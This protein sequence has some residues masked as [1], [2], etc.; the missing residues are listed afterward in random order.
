MNTRKVWILEIYDNFGKGNAFGEIAPLKGLSIEL[1]DEENFHLKLQEVIEN[2]EYYIHHLDELRA[3]PS[4]LFGVEMAYLAYKRPS[5]ILFQTD[6]TLGKKSIP[7]NALVWMNDAET[8]KKDVDRLLKTKADCI[9]LKIGGVNFE[10]ELE[11]L[12]FIRKQK[13]KEDLLLRLDAN[14]N[15]GKDYEYQLKALAEYDIDSI[16][17][18]LPVS[19]IDATKALCEENIIPIALDE[20]LLGHLFF[21][22]KQKL[23]TTIKPQAIVI[24][25]SLHGGMQGTREWILAADEHRIKWWI[26]SS[27]ESN[28]GLGVLAQFASKY[29]STYLTHQGLGTGRLYKN[30]IEPSYLDMQDYR[31]MMI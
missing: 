28:L 17:Q 26:T 9:K 8:M 12:D 22:E 16:E 15:L 7:I 13:P 19:E 4:I 11:I 20:Q 5:H 31:L 25:P 23:L 21:P 3:Y 30:N 2:I 10:D 6:F 24:K 29:P 14:G 1:E 18:P 27:L